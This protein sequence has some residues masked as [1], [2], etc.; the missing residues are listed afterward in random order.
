[1]CHSGSTIKRV[2]FLELIAALSAALCAFR[3]QFL[4]SQKANHEIFFNGGT[5]SL[6]RP[7]LIRAIT[8]NFGGT[9][10]PHY[11]GLLAFKQLDPA[12]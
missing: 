8:V 11:F 3:L 1:M 2:G 9:Q 12:R 6:K 4:P 10:L 7:G 5:S